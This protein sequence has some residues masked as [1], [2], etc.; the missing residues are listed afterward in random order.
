MRRSSKRRRYSL[1][2]RPPP[3]LFSAAVSVAFHFL[4]WHASG[5]DNLTKY[6]RAALKRAEVKHIGPGDG[7]SARIPGFPGLIVFGETRRKALVE[8]DSALQG[9]I[10]LSLT[11]GDGLPALH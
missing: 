4:H 11:R 2:G 7:Y 5:V 9:W 8:L 1:N 6:R 3:K 10:E